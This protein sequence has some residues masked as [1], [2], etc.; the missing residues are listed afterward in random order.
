MM[1]TK[2]LRLF[3]RQV[4]VDCRNK[5]L[6]AWCGEFF[7]YFLAAKLAFLAAFFCLRVGISPWAMA[8]ARFK[9]RT[10]RVETRIRLPPMRIV[11]R[12][13][14]CFRLVAILEWLRE[15][16]TLARLPESWSMRDIGMAGRLAE[17]WT[18][19]K[20]EGACHYKEHEF[21]RIALSRATRFS[22]DC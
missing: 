16:A 6:S 8:A 9:E 13:T 4:S 12:F 20:R 18:F 19:V 15:L 7:I 17:S 21:D 5:K 11:C 22:G 2:H 3:V 10:V 14:F 1:R